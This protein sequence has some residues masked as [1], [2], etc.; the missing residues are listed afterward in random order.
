[1]I[2][3]FRVANSEAGDAIVFETCLVSDESLEP[4]SLHSELGGRLLMMVIDIPLHKACLPGVRNTHWR[5]LQLE[6][7]DKCCRK[8]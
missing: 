8:V 1:M 4:Q 5:V 3:S 7:T 2:N 6:G